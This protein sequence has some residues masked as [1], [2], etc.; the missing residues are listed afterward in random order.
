MMTSEDTADLCLLGWLFS[1]LWK[2]QV[3][4]RYIM[5]R[6]QYN[7]KS[8]YIFVYLLVILILFKV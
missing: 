6:N 8:F 2:E 1:L 5:D 3:E 4:E 7:Y